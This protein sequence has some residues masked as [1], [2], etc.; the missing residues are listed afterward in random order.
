MSPHS[1][2]V[3]P[4]P[5]F[6]SSS[7]PIRKSRNHSHFMLYMMSWRMAISQI[8]SP[9]YLPCSLPVTLSDDTVGPCPISRS[10][11]EILRSSNTAGRGHISLISP[12]G[13]HG[14][15]QDKDRSTDP[16]Y[17]HHLNQPKVLTGSTIGPG[18]LLLGFTTPPLSLDSIPIRS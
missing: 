5:T 7:A 3:W 18:Y 12:G 1:T 16:P 11:A 2:S 6:M 17:V 9:R 13:V 14:L 15:D 8:R 10:C 4:S